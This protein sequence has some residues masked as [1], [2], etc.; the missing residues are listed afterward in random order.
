M[1]GKAVCYMHGGN[2]PAG[3]ASPS[4]KHGRYSKVLPVR[5]AERYAEAKADPELT[6]L[7]DEIA[8]TVVRLCE[9]FAGTK[10]GEAVRSRRWQAIDRTMVLLKKLVDSEV[11]RKATLKQMLAVDQVMALLAALTS[12]IRA[13]V[14]AAIAD[15]V[16]ARALLAAIQA[17]VSRVLALPAKSMPSVEGEGS[18]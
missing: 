1:H 12:S 3:I 13:E 4:F 16:Q 15:E 17:H 9:L 5:L 18:A 11:K 10:V 14:L 8:V 6:N 2:S 7:E